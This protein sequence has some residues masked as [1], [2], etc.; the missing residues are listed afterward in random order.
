[1][2]TEQNRAKGKETTTAAT[3][4]SITRAICRPLSSDGVTVVSG[5]RWEMPFFLFFTTHS[6]S[7]AASYRRVF[8]YRSLSSFSALVRAE[9]KK[10]RSFWWPQRKATVVTSAQIVEMKEEEQERGWGMDKEK[11]RSK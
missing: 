6:S 4:C 3:S 9:S 2:R 8:S 7:S 5:R 11:E 10:L 1:M